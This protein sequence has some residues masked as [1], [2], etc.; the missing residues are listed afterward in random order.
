M[1]FS[2][3]KKSADASPNIAG[4]GAIGTEVLPYKT[5]GDVKPVPPPTLPRKQSIQDPKHPPKVVSRANTIPNAEPTGFSVPTNGVCQQFQEAGDAASAPDVPEFTE[6]HNKP[7]AVPPKPVNKL[8]LT[9][10]QISVHLLSLSSSSEE[11]IVSVSPGPNSSH[12]RRPPPTPDSTTENDQSGEENGSV[13]SKIGRFNK[14]PS[15]SI[16]D[17]KA[18]EDNANVRSF[19]PPL[20]PRKQSNATPQSKPKNK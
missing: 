17:S 19:Q 20:L 3:N 4:M 14:M 10:K 18:N 16:N 8:S 13:F 15:D 12:Q 7:P 1:S 2:N 5:S 9:K 6:D 11:S